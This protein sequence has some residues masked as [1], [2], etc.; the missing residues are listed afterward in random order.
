[1]ITN[2]VIALVLL[3]HSPSL[4]A[5]DGWVL[6]IETTGI[7]T[8]VDAQKKTRE[9]REPITW[10]VHDG[11]DTLAACRAGVAQ[12]FQGLPRPDLDALLSDKPLPRMYIL[13]SQTLASHFEFQNGEKLHSQYRHLCLP[14][15]VDPRERGKG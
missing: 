3:A 13:N 14:G 15:T 4:L 6:W 1:M 11:Y 5:E 10:S 9:G 8:I 12:K 7:R 2:L